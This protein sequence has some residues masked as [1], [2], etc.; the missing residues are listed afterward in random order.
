MYSPNFKLN[1]YD[2]WNEND[3]KE[4]E[5]Y[6]PPLSAYSPEYS[7]SSN[8]KFNYYIQNNTKQPNQ[9]SPSI[10]IKMNKLSTIKYFGYKSLKPLGV[11]KTMEQ[12]DMEFQETDFGNETNLETNIEHLVIEEVREG[13]IEGNTRDLDDEIPDLDSDDGFMAQD[14]EYQN[15]H[16][17]PT[18]DDEDMI[19][20]DE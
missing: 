1:Y 11:N 7:G 15:D 8:L 20:E 9:I 16:S 4:I 10:Q 13:R 12:M 14:V 18:R 19:L 3:S 5:L 17:I 6:Q 2:L